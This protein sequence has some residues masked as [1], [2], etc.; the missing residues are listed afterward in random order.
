MKRETL[1]WQVP[2]FVILFFLGLLLSTRFIEEGYASYLE[3]QDT[4]DLVA[5]WKDLSEKHEDL[6]QEIL[7]LNR[8]KT[9]LNRE[10]SQGQ[11]ALSNM[12]GQLTSLHMY[13]GLVSVQGPGIKITVS[14]ESPL[15][16]LDLVDI[17][18]ELWASGAEAVSINDV[19]VTGS[20]AFFFVETDTGIF[21]TASGKKLGYPIVIKAIGEPKTLEKGLT[22]PGGVMDNLNTLYKVYPEISAEEKVVL[23]AR[24]NAPVPISSIPAAITKG[25]LGN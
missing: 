25:L 20:T 4:D 8:Q 22:F 7:E 15:L 17:V 6:Q 14:D 18:N 5:I 21:L 1:R 9:A 12:E 16:Y 23:P 11:D 10:T 3:H 24:E 2:L 19:R 13:N